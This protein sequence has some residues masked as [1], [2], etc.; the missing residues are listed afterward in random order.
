MVKE[1]QNNRIQN[2][3]YFNGYKK[4]NISQSKVLKE[5]KIF[6]K[7]NSHLNFNS[8]KQWFEK[9]KETFDLD[10][11]VILEEKIFIEFLNESKIFDYLEEITGFKY[12]LGDIIVRKTLLRKGYTSWHRDTYLNNG[13]TIGRTPPLIKLFIYPKLNNG[14]IIQLKLKVGSHLKFYRNKYFDKFF[15]FF[16][17]QINIRTS[18]EEALLFNSA[19]Y[20]TTTTPEKNGSFRIIYNFCSEKQVMQFK[21]Y[22][23]I[24][25]FLKKQF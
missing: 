19:I 7:K 20:H 16:S 8:N 3:F 4:L 12:T 17:N 25:R 2:H 14:N 13:E 22:P 24:Q 11:K 23:T 18:N 6:L 21:N 10:I 9:Y 15:N 1:Y 5:I